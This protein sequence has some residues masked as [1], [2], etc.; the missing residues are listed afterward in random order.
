MPED[1]LSD[2]V[3]AGQGNPLFLEQML[4]MWQDDGTIELGSSGWELTRRRAVC[5]SHPPSRRSLRLAST[6]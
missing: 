1:I 5:R 2:I 6:P 3:A 4:A